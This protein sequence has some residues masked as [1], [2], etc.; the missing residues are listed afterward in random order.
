MRDFLEVPDGAGAGN[1]FHELGAVKA[2]ALGQLF[3]VGVDFDQF[4]AFQDPA[5]EGDREEGLD[6]AGAARDDADGA[7]G[8][9]GGGGGVAHAP[10]AVA[11]VFAAGVGGEVAPLVGQG[12]G[13]L[14]GLRLD[15]GRHPLR[16]LHGRLGVIRDVELEEHIG[17]AHD[18]QA[19]L[20]GILGSSPG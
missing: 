14:P 9:D 3:E 1:V 11:V 16:H 4:G 15:E 10:Q 17:E 8:G 20:P 12:G 6:A 2:P 19:D 13:G 5:H 7:G 18:P